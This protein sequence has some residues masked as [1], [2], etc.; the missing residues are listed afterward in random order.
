MPNPDLSA[1]A[2]QQPSLTLDDFE[3]AR[4]SAEA[5]THEAHVY[6]AWLYLQEYSL[7]DTLA[8]YS[9]GLKNLTRKLGAEEKYNETI[10]WFFVLTIADR[11][12]QCPS[13]TWVDFRDRNPD[14]LLHAGRLLADHYSPQR[15]ASLLAR[16]QFVLPDLSPLATKTVSQP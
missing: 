6:V 2:L 10:T 4:V 7:A 11:R 15:L 13:S 8:R 12:Q 1:P 14:L 16:R 3:S 9:S 5:F